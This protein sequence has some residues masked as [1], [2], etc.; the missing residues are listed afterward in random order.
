MYQYILTRILMSERLLPDIAAS[1]DSKQP[2]YTAVSAQAKSVGYLHLYLC[3]DEPE[4]TIRSRNVN[5]QHVSVEHFSLF[6]IF[7]WVVYLS[8]R[9]RNRTPPV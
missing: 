2:T 4:P 7:I 5:R 9:W 8:D 3:A 1:I 6:V